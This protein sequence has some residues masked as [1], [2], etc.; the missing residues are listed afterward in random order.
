MTAV[1]NNQDTIIHCNVISQTH[2][3]VF[4]VKVQ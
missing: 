3:T 2:I 1:L 4:Y